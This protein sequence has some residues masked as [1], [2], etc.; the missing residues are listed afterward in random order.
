MKIPQKLKL[1]LYDFVYTIFYNWLYVLY[2]KCDLPFA[3]C[4]NMHLF[5]RLCLNDVLS[6]V[7]IYI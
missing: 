2:T 7:S 3:G 1:K 6:D 4:A 5:F